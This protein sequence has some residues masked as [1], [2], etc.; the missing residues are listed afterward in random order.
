MK[1]GAG[2]T[3]NASGI[4]TQGNFYIEKN[5]FGVDVDK[6]F[7][8]DALINVAGID[9]P[10]RELSADGV[11]ISH[12]KVS[13]KSLQSYYEKA[14]LKAA[15]SVFI[16]NNSYNINASLKAPPQTYPQGLKPL[17][18]AIPAFDAEVHIEGSL[19]KP[20]I[21]AD[22]NTGSMTF[23]NVAIK[24]SHIK[25]LIT[26]RDLSILSAD[27][28]LS[29][30]STINAHGQVN[31]NDQN[32][33]LITQQKN[34]LSEDLLK[35]VNLNI[36]T[37][38]EIDAD[39]KVTGTFKNNDVNF[40]IK[41][42]GLIKR[43]ALHDIKLN[44]NTHFDV[45]VNYVLDN[46]VIIRHGHMSDA[47]GLNL[48]TAGLVNLKTK[49]YNFNYNIYLDN[50]S[51]YILYIDNLH[52]NKLSSQGV[53]KSNNNT[54]FINGIVSSN[55][56][57][58]KNYKLDTIKFNYEL[59]NNNL[60]LTKMEAQAYDGFIHAVGLIKDLSAQRQIEGFIS[61][62]SIN[63]KKVG[64]L[65]APF[66][67]E[68][69]LGAKVLLSGSL[70]KP[71]I[72]FDAQ[73]I[74]AVVDNFALPFA[75]LSGTFDEN[76]LKIA[77]FSVE[78]FLGK[79]IGSHLHY[80]LKTQKLKGILKFY[81]FNVAALAPYIDNLK[82]F[83]NGSLSILGT[84][85][86]P[87]L[88]GELSAK[89]ISYLGHDLGLGPL[90][91]GLK[92]ERMQGLNQEDLVFSLATTLKKGDSYI[93]LQYAQAL[94]K[95]TINAYAELNSFP[96]DSS[97]LSFKESH[98]GFKGILNSTFSLQGISAQP[99]L[100]ADI[101]LSEFSFFDPAKRSSYK[102][103]KT[104]GPATIKASVKKGILNA[105][106]LGSLGLKKESVALNLQ[107]PCDF[108]A[109][110]ISVFGSLDYDHWE[111]VLLGLRN[112]FSSLSAAVRIDS[113]L[114]KIKNKAWDFKSNFF[115]DHF[116]ASMPAIPH[117]ELS[118]PAKFSYSN[119]KLVFSNDI[120]L[121]FSPG[122]LIISGNISRESINTK[123]EGAMPL[124]GLRFFTPLI[125]RAEGLARGK[126]AIEGSFTNPL[127]DGHIAVDSGSL[128]TFNKFF[129]TLEF[130]EG[131]V[132]FKK[133]S[134]R[135]FSTNFKNIKLALGDGRIFLNGIFDKNKNIYDLSLEAHN[136]IA[137]QKGEFIEGDLN[138][139]THKDINNQT[140]LKGSIALTDGLVSRNF[141]LRNFVAQASA[142]EGPSVPNFFDNL[143]LNIDLDIAIRQF[144]ASARMLTIDVDAN[145]SGQIKALGS[146]QSPQ[147]NG[148][149]SVSEGKITF[150]AATFDLY[151]S[152]VDLDGQKPQISITAVQD[153][154]KEEFP[155]QQDTTIQ[156]SL[157]GNV[158]QLKLELKPITGDMK[159]SQTKIFL[160]LLMP[161]LGTGADDQIRSSAQQAAMAF[162]GEVFLRPLT[163][164]LAELLEGKTK[165]KIQFGSAFE[166][167]SVSLRLNWKIGPRIEAQGSYMYFSDD[168]R[169]RHSEQSSLMSDSY[170]V[171]DLKLK[172]ILFDHKPFGPLF[173][174]SSFGAHHLGE[175][176]YEPRGLFKL[177]YRILSK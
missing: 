71:L 149:I 37:H 169:R 147:F 26:T 86:A 99:E 151:E 68:G 98:F 115:L 144:R 5:H 168:Y 90:R 81:D 30:A 138:L 112:E 1:H 96:F 44:N 161:R 53:I 116:K 6:V 85:K 7:I 167:G 154:S 39:T 76:D 141:D 159:L 88:E 29:K 32:F 165:T 34:F 101:V 27:L 166:P 82:G 73:L 75:L 118:Q 9:L 66:N 13:V 120:F 177:N 124:L 56:I 12:D 10:L 92:P 122:N 64:P 139:K 63:L 171:G 113:M 24:S 152:R 107:G 33:N 25:A 105:K 172:L 67:L 22:I 78:G 134:P 121:N 74:N 55:N 36:S 108:N 94:H 136:I 87:R 54:L 106:L 14:K 57:S 23:N 8:V 62:E 135:S 93:S 102:S 130:K 95:K 11:E 158:D 79:I 69:S 164:E 129:E 125:Q 49:E 170:L 140:I 160:M 111:E 46:K 65:F 117:I 133:R 132:E 153:F 60:I 31:F 84:L 15:G 51:N 3:I 119:E 146:L 148:S 52:T 143:A 43:G 174:E 137:K 89:N 50:I 123:L 145:L 100:N 150:P 72:N 156:L 61:S 162:S 16:K 35:L 83:L 104:H 2:V 128:I 58:I 131:S 59:N 20:L 176:T 41:T 110:N 97:L 38:G 70:K 103:E 109:C 47:Q 157:S 19:T 126:L 173:L 127:F 18:F 163:N 42:S 4:K 80:D 45:D 28:K 142:R 21:N 175:G 77:H 40:N 155:I 48:K 114:T 91:V 17:P